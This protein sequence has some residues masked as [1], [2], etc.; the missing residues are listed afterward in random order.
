MASYKKLGL[1]II[2]ILCALPLASFI[3][4]VVLMTQ[5]REV[6][7]EEHHHD[8]VVERRV[9]TPCQDAKF[10]WLHSGGKISAEG[11]VTVGN[12]TLKFHTTSVSSPPSDWYEFTANKDPHYEKRKNAGMR[13]LESKF[14]AL[15][16]RGTICSLDPNDVNNFRICTPDSECIDSL[17]KLVS[18][19]STIAAII[20]CV[21]LCFLGGFIVVLCICPDKKISKRKVNLEMGSVQDQ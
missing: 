9:L 12:D 21:M 14:N 16:S 17:Y 11:L 1:S 2:A 5:G 15:I 20:F 6:V 3:V 18:W 13:W 8:D 10:K 7:E 19:L 4:V